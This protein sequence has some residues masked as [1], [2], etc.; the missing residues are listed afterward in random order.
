MIGCVEIASQ[1]RTYNSSDAALFNLPLCLELALHEGRQFPGAHASK[2]RFGAATLPVA[3]M[4]SFD[5]VL[6]AFRA[7]VEHAVDEMAEVLGWLEACYREHRTTPFNSMI[8]EGCLESGRDVT[9]GGALYDMTSIQAVGLADTGDSLHALRKLVFEDRAFSLVDFVDIVAANFAGQDVLQ[10]RLQERFEHYGNDNPQA[11]EPTALAADIYADAITR[12]TN[13]RGGKW[14]PGFYSMTCG[15]SFGKVTGALP[16]GRPAGARLSNGF[17]P[18]DGSDISGPTALLRSASGLNVHR[19]ANGGA[20]N[21]KFDA[22]TVGGAVGR[23]ALTS[24]FRTYLVDQDGMQIQV[25][26]LDAETLRKAKADPSEFPNLLVRVS[27]Y[28]AYFNDLQPEIQDE[29]IERTA[30]GFQ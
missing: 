23:R 21:V 5:D 22:R 30:H 16:N 20:L 3:K 11:D 13:S 1:G 27:G 26:V 17:S 15:T 14:L 12:H 24:L 8:T 4:K 19:W 28:C 6:S 18:A 29:I 2:K 25:N 7:Q 10:L 9:W